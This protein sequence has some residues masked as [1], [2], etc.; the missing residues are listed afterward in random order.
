MTDASSD[1]I[2]HVHVTRTGH[3]E[4][5]VPAAL[6]GEEHEAER[7]AF[8]KADVARQVAAQAEAVEHP[9]RPLTPPGPVTLL[10]REEA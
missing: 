5:Q 9:A 4:V 1:T 7:E 3:Y 2:L 8:I 6:E 10:T